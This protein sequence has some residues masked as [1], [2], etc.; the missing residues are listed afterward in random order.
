LKA[1]AIL[2]PIFKQQPEHPGVAHYLIHSYDYPPIAKHGMDAAIRY[3][4]IAPDAPH[5][6]HMPSHIFTRVGAWK[7][8]VRSNRASAEAGSDKTFDKWHAYDYL[9]YAHLQQGEDAA[10]RK[11]VADAM[12]NPARVDHFATAYA[13]A[14]MPAEIVLERGDWK[15]AA[16]LDVAPADGFPWQKYPH[17]E[18]LNAFARGLGAAMSGDTAAARSELDRL[19]KLRD[20]TASRKLGYW[21]EEIEV[22]AGIVQGMTLVRGRQTRRL[23][24]GAAGLGHPR[25]CDRE[26]RRDAGAPDSCT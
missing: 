8:S 7:E 13:Y 17:A 15:A 16:K 18:S 3:D 22:Q 12:N 21:V 9:V 25:G 5:A 20:V 6:L 2:E 4:R 19:Q 1:A 23:P 24:R 10:A 26:A 14:A 11:V